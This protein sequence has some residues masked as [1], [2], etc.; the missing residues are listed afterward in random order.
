MALQLLSDG[1]EY[2]A[3]QSERFAGEL[4]AAAGSPVE[5]EDLVRFV[6]LATHTIG[7]HLEDWPRAQRLAERVM[8][9]RTPD[10]A[11]GKAWAHLSIA[12]SL[13]GN[14]AGG[15]EAE[16]VWMGAAPGGPAA[17]AVELKFMMV[18]ALV[19][20]GRADAAEPLYLAAV[21]L[22]RRVEA[23]GVAEAANRVSGA[24]ATDLLEAPSRTPAEAALMRRAAEASHAFALRGG[25]WYEDQVGHYLRALVA[26]VDGDPDGAIFHVEAAKAL[27]QAH[28]GSPIDETF[29]HLTTAHARHLRG[30]AEAAAE[31]LARSDAIAATFDKP[32]LLA[33]HADER[34]RVFPHLP[35]R[36]VGAQ[37]A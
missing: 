37:S 29:L 34:A 33:W 7:E 36:I 2:H 32:D 15:A 12:R 20:D 13:A 28:G 25:G 16:L 17:A 23:P 22:A 19:G 8:A 26:N 21:D 24:L 3:T 27:L 9:G 31:A 1:W 14:P 5:A 11:T 30:E 18:A 10:A 4:E 35:P 6:R